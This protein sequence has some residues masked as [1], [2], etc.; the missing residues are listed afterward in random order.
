MGDGP[1]VGSYATIHPGEAPSTGSDAMLH[2]GIAPVF[3]PADAVRS[4]EGDSSSSDDDVTSPLESHAVG[5]CKPTYTADGAVLPSPAPSSTAPAGT[6]PVDPGGWNPFQPM[7]Y[8]APPVGDAEL[9]WDAEA[10]APRMVH[11]EVGLLQ[12]H[13]MGA[14]C[15]GMFGPGEVIST[16]MERDVAVRPPSF[17]GLGMA[18]PT[19]GSLGRVVGTG[20]HGRAT[21][22]Q[23]NFDHLGSAFDGMDIARD[24]GA[25]PIPRDKKP[26]STPPR[27][28]PNVHDRQG[29]P[30][31]QHPK[32]APVY[33]SP[34][35]SRPTYQQGRR[36]HH[37][38]G[39]LQARPN[40]ASPQ[41]RPHHQVQHPFHH[42]GTHQRPNTASPHSHSHSASQQPRPQSAS[43]QLQPGNGSP[44]P[45]PHS[46][47][48]QHQRQHMSHH[49]RQHHGHR[50]RSQSGSRPPPERLTAPQQPR[51]PVPARRNTM[52]AG[53]SPR[54]RSEMSATAHASMRAD[55]DNGPTARQ[56]QSVRTQ[57]AHSAGH[58]SSAAAAAQAA[59]RHAHDDHGDRRGQPVP[60]ART[61][62]CTDATATPALPS[63]AA[64][65]SEDA[66]PSAPRVRR[67]SVHKVPDDVAPR[68][69]TGRTP[70]GTD[71][72][73]DARAKLEALRV[74]EGTAGN[75]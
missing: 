63:A 12:Q 68:R 54:R 37:S 73:P 75:D 45:H 21:T 70:S 48:H 33:V 74:L 71:S 15:V 72:S 36:S 18:T 7:L 16:V 4:S 57:H 30:Q 20:Q 40:T 8:A 31:Q 47:A 53:E 59:V 23:M 26:R 52:S 11:S 56:R 50:P 60:A 27:A 38:T 5:V 69:S 24:A 6:P 41:S 32:I 25:P 67:P 13:A 49:Q 2:P 19:P 44:N 66:I 28:K 9:G 64:S 65:R 46:L 3:T 10:G 51:H 34:L 17:P 35:R 61:P 39:M 14:P 55:S 62:T 29:S 43:P 42:N 1:P 58:T 22:P